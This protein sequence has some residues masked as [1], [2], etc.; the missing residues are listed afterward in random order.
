MAVVVNYQTSGNLDPSLVSGGGNIGP[1]TTFG[2]LP[3]DVDAGVTYRVTDVGPTDSG[4]LWV[5]GTSR[6]RTLGGRQLHCAAQGTIAAPLATLSGATG[7]FVLPAGD[8]VSGGSI[9]LPVGLPQVGQGVQV[10]CKV[11]HRGTGGAWNFVARI[12]TSDTSS[13][14]NFA[15]VTGTATDDQGAWVEQDMETVT[16]TSFISSGYSVPNSVGVGALVLRNSNFNNAAQMYL[17]F[18]SSTLNA[19]DFLDL[20]SYRVYLLG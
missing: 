11:R 6:W 4:S 10:S 15:Q 1:A 13:D 9:L 16:A 12:G 7:K 2:N 5:K 18:Y 20:I 19:A 3:S 8:R 14:S 17:G